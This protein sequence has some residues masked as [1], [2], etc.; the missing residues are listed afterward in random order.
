MKSPPPSSAEIPSVETP[1]T[2][3]QVVIPIDDGE[4]AEEPV[5]ENPIPIDEVLR[6]SPHVVD[7][8]KVAAQAP[9]PAAADVSA[10]SPPENGNDSS[11]MVNESPEFKPAVDNALVE[12]PPATAG[13]AGNSPA[14]PATVDGHEGPKT[15]ISMLDKPAKRFTRSSLIGP[16]TEQE[17]VAMENRVETKDSSCLSEKPTSRRFTRSLLKG[18]AEDTS[19]GEVSAT[20]TSGSDG[21]RGSGVNADDGSSDM[22]PTK[23][24]ELK[25]SKKIALNK[26]PTNVRDLLGTGLLEGLPVKYV[27]YVG[28]PYGLEGV[29]KG[30]GILCSCSFCKGAK[31]VSAYNFEVH[32]GSTK[33]HPSDYIFLENG[34]SLRDV[35]RACTSAPLDMLE[36]AIQNV[37]GV[38]PPSKPSIC[39]KCEEIFHTPRTGKFAL[40]C[41]SCLEPT[42]QMTPRPFQGSPIPAKLPSKVSAGDGSNGSYKKISSQ[43][44]SIIQTKVLAGDASDGS[45]KNT[46]SH[47]KVVGKLTR[48]DLGLHKLV[49]MDDILPEGTEVGYYVRGMRLL[50]GYIKD[51]GICCD[52]CNSVV[53]PSQFEAHAGR[54][55]R[56]KPYNNIYTSNG[57]SLHE[58]SVSL[59]KGRKLSATE[60]DDL[61][62]ICADGGDLLLCDL[63]PRAF[64]KECV[65]LSSIPKG[66]WYCRYCQ[67]MHQRE[68]CLST[69]DNAIAAGR[70]A[71]VDP[72]EQIITR[73]IRIVTTSTDIGGCAL[74]RSHDFSRSGFDNRTVM[75]CDQCE[76]E[77]HVGC[78]KDHNMCD[79]KELPEG[80]WFCSTN[81]SRIHADLQELLRES[82]P[83]EDIHVDIIMK[84]CEEKGIKKDAKDDVRWRLLSG[85]TSPADSKL[86]LSEAVTIFHES[87]DPIVD[88]VTGRDLIPSMVYGREVR[89]QDFGGMYCVVLTLNS[90]VVS[91]GILR[92]LGCEVAEL[93][94]VATSKDSQGLGY[95]QSLFACIE[96][97]L[98]SLKIKHFV[99][100]SADE[101]KS[102]WTKKFGFSKITQE[103]LVEYAKGARPMI[104]QGTSWLY[105]PVPC[106][107]DSFSGNPT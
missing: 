59:S 25:M 82:K 40:F 6:G 14:K 23:K 104:F 90:S 83:L 54:A 12:D 50:K 55:Q 99:L 49:F 33:K 9:P 93:P 101:A 45:T 11:E 15:E 53:S 16:E 10:G 65:G 8:P 35:L 2:Q 32:A 80:E 20:T 37:V 77:Y 28:K 70:V 68:K 19:A 27:V 88:A 43:K 44:K 106:T 74:C 60:N 91:A 72:I 87:F 7:S 47:K 81:C 46:S 36:S 105:K 42:K 24:M 66:D 3:E 61:C 84:K 86:L 17:G 4:L 58:L 51:S 95:F 67:D 79:L 5:V 73:C 41:D 13:A 103:Q 56:R 76:K 102:I 29:I 94:L 92:V 30:N 64:H 107:Q 62:S 34:K 98:E 75:L 48:K 21:T 22:T 85:K 18:T 78:L 31:V 89:D 71:G 52:C 69:N 100:P 39:Q 63:C 1:K 96:K 38:M 26:L 97:L 57:V